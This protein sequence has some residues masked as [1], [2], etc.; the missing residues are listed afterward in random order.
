MAGRKVHFTYGETVREGQT[1]R[2]PITGAWAGHI[3]FLSYKTACGLTLDPDENK[4]IDYVE[5]VT[6]SRCVSGILRDAPEL[7]THCRH[8]LHFHWTARDDRPYQ[9]HQGRDG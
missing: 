6:C 1:F 4:V 9:P 5:G 7:L 2:D 3:S 8:P